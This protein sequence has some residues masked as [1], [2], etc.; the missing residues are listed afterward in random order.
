MVQTISLGNEFFLDLFSVASF[1]VWTAILAAWSN[2]VAMSEEVW[3]VPIVFDLQQTGV[4]VAP[5]SEKVNQF[6]VYYICFGSF[7]ADVNTEIL[8]DW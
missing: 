8:S 7:N 2:A 6:H 5:I 3:R 4:A 1:F